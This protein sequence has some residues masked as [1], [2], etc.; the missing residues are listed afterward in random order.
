MYDCSVRHAPLAHK[1]TGKERDSESGL[2]NFGARYDASSMG[3]FMTPD[4]KTVSAKVWDPQTWNRYSYARNNPLAYLDFDGLEAIEIA[5]FWRTDWLATGR[6]FAAGDL[7]T[8]FAGIAHTSAPPVNRSFLPR[9]YASGIHTSGNPVVADSGN[10][11]A[12]C[13]LA[14]SSEY[15]DFTRG[16]R[17][18]ADFK[19]DGSNN[20]T[21][22]LSEPMDKMTGQINGPYGSPTRWAGGVVGPPPTEFD[23][24]VHKPSISGLTDKE[25]DALDSALGASLSEGYDEAKY[26]AQVAVAFEEA[27]RHPK[28]KS[29]CKPF[30]QQ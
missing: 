25:L 14:C 4:P 21:A 19:T 24:K 17:L 7:L 3:R 9:G 10:D 11:G 22:T 28:H 12:M 29:S 1:F 2:D 27:D 13:P 15:R 8:A 18:V 23:V 30:C 6:G 26:Q 20:V 16:Y 5:Y